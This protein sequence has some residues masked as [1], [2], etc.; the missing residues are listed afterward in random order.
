MSAPDHYRFEDAYDESGVYVICRRF[1][2]LSETPKGYWLIL[3][4]YADQ[5]DGWIK[6]HKRF[7]FKDG[8]RKWAYTTREAAL[9]SYKIRKAR[10]LQRLTFDYQKIQ[11]VYEHMAYLDAAADKQFCG[12]PKAFNDFIWE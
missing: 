3:A 2:V 6:R 10:H 8:A 11:T 9:H 7:I 12:K 1:V 4:E 5:W